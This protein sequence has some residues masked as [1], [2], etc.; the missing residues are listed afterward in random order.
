MS[1]NAEERS[2]TMTFR[3]PIDLAHNLL[4]EP[5]FDK[6]YHQL[7][8]VGGLMLARAVLEMDAYIKSNALPQVGLSAQPSTEDCGPAGSAPIQAH[9]K[10]QYKRLVAQG[11][12]V[13]PP[14]APTPETDKFYASLVHPSVPKDMVEHSFGAE[15][16]LARKLERQRNAAPADNADMQSNILGKSMR[17]EAANKLLIEANVALVDAVVSREKAEAELAAA[18][19][20][21]ATEKD[22]HNRTIEVW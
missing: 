10:S 18:K 14:I 8:Q 22:L 6:P 4:A 12:N 11:A 17:L 19:E 9:D 5:E 20:Q 3:A 16:E 2:A 1:S 21:L 13:L 15:R 7:T